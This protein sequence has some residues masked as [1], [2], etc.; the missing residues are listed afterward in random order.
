MFSYLVTLSGAH[1]YPSQLSKLSK[2]DVT[3]RKDYG[4]TSKSG[5]KVES[6]YISIE[7]NSIQE[8]HAVVMGI[9]EEESNITEIEF[10]VIRYY[11]EQ[12]NLEFSANELKLITDLNAHLCISCSKNS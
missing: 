2:L 10:N 3:T 6:G 12:C 1:F 9:K 5:R 8:L 7:A 11:E 4:E